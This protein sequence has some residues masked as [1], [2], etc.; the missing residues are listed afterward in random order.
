M[1]EPVQTV[2]AFR[3][4][5]WER[6]RHR[7]AGQRVVELRLRSLNAPVTRRSSRVARALS[8]P[9]G[10]WPVAGLLSAVCNS[11]VSAGHDP[12]NP[13]C[14]CKHGPIPGDKCTCG[15][16]A[17]T[18]LEII[19]SYLVKP[20][21][22]VMGVVEMGGRVIPADQGYRAEAAR[23]AAILKI[24]PMFTLDH[25]TLDA[26]AAE[27]SVPA[28]VPF[29]TDPEDYRRLVSGVQTADIDDEFRD[30]FPDAG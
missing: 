10:D 22:P 26:I 20:E 21:V 14:D 13:D 12:E 2:L 5:R 7:E 16:Y 24:D 3:V 19:N 4:W 8:S 18:D 28:I 23:V 15:I 11:A 27:Y 9:G 6:R 17:A 25:A 29:S 30:F 1:S